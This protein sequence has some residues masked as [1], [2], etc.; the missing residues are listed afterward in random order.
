MFHDLRELAYGVVIAD[1]GD[2]APAPQDSHRAEIAAFLL[3]GM[4]AMRYDA[5]GVG[6][7]DLALGPA[8]LHDAARRLPL[9]GANV[10]FGPALA[11]SLP[12][13]RWVEKNGKKVAV[14]GVIDPIL[15]FE[16]EGA[17]EMAES[18]MVGDAVLALR[19]AMTQ[20]GEAGDAVV[21]LIHADRARAIEILNGIG[22]LPRAPDIAV[23]G[24]EPMGPRAEEKVDRT[25][26]M[27]PG[28]RSR[29]VSLFTL[30]YADS[31]AVLRAG[32]Q[33]HRLGNLSG[34][35]PEIDAMTKAFQAK[36]G[37]K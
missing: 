16:S 23:V 4:A 28:P 29:E 26:V 13:V 8:Y 34:G 10:R 20:I 33:V 14:I 1:A 25:F 15:Y 17:F 11:E 27:Q 32:L 18:L 30:T 35:D 31:G 19:G 5:V 37:I 22:D 3:E 36:H 7:L 21:V 24:H 2:F 12:A 6:E 9:V